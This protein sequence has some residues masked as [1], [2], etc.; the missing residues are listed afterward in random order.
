[1]QEKK[2]VS[3][4]KILF[5]V[6]YAPTVIRTRPY[7]F[8][9]AL[10]GRGHSIT[11]ATL[12][13]NE[14]E[15]QALSDLAQIP[16]VRVLAYPIRRSQILANL[17]RAFFNG[18]PLQVWYSWLP[19]LKQAILQELEQ[20]NY[21]AIH[22]EHL[23]GSP[24]GLILQKEIAKRGLR[25]P[26]IYDS[27]DSISLLYDRATQ[28][29]SNF[30]WKWITR[31]ELPRTKSYE[32]FLVR[33]FNQILVTTPMDKQA[34]VE[35]ASQCGGL[36][37]EHEQ[38]VGVITNG[39]DLEYF[40][41]STEKRQTDTVIFSGKMSYHAND[42][43]AKYILTKVMPLVWKN[44][45]QTQLWLVGKSPSK[46]L[47]K[48]CANDSRIKLTGYVSDIRSYIQQ[49][50]VALVPLQ[51][52]TGIQNKALEAMACATP[53]V[54]SSL[55]AKPLNAVVGS[56]IFVADEAPVIALALINILSDEN[57]QTQVGMAGRRYVELHHDWNSLSEQLE[58]IYIRHL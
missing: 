39:V 58:K 57:L 11:V 9:K 1:M 35:L 49:A 56:E 48:M 18:D 25:I 43:A 5:Q 37:Q 13:E 17:M 28:T 14:A 22:C 54:A 20:E 8:I 7:N 24:Y 10:A 12:W 6:S 26:V 44:R 15:R 40:T 46:S 29:T 50:S 47:Q 55:A 27:V 19:T 38:K 52:A 33:E 42:S 53:V 31:F 2:T 45:P 16:G 36:A 4:L 41:P 3:N 34:L 30:A 32:G 23:R 51:Y 21:D